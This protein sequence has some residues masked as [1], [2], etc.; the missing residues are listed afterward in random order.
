MAI[1]LINDNLERRFRE[2]LRRDNK[3]MHEVLTEIINTYIDSADRIYNI[4]H[5]VVHLEENINQQQRYLALDRIRNVARNRNQINHWILRSYFCTEH[6]GVA[7]LNEMKDYFL[8]NRRDCTEWQFQ[9]NFNQMLMDDGNS[10]GHY[11]NVRGIYG[12]KVELF[13]PVRD[14][15]L[16]YRQ[17]FID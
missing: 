9:N 8:K 17:S 15:I 5:P 11:F 1:R 2:V 7:S 6:D 16:R 10:H 14:G 12:D 3:R 4:A 13:G